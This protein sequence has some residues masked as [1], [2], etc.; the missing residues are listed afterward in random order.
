MACGIRGTSSCMG[1]YSACR[2]CSASTAKSG[3]GRLSHSP[4]PP[5]N[6]MAVSQV[7]H[8]QCCCAR[9]WLEKP[10]R[11]WMPPLRQ[12][13]RRTKKRQAKAG[14]CS[15]KKRGLRKGERGDA[16]EGRP[17]A[18]SLGVHLPQGTQGAC[19]K[20]GEQQ[21]RRHGAQGHGHNKWRK[22]RQRL[23]AAQTGLPTQCATSPTYVQPK[24]FTQCVQS[25]C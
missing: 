5:A 17:N 15:Q 22:N 12:Q 3:R 25:P 2:L 9:W 18:I 19:P 14:T 20:T 24:P 21:N 1:Y 4:F 8:G 16:P 23:A 11:C 10:M 6:V 13:R 7:H